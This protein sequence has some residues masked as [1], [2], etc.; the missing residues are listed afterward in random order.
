MR[1]TVDDFVA[2]QST[3]DQHISTNFNAEGRKL[4]KTKNGETGGLR[5]LRVVLR[6]Q[7]RKPLAGLAFCRGD[8]LPVVQVRVVGHQ[9]QAQ[10]RGPQRQPGSAARQP[11]LRPSPGT[12]QLWQDSGLRCE[13]EW[14]LWERR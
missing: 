6:E 13:V 14:K 4:L 12:C 9:Q 7:K 1:P 10:S 2:V 5:I 8:F 11:G 3:Q